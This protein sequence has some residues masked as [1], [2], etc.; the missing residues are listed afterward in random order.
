MT[1]REIEEHNV[2][3]RINR[4]RIEQRRMTV[5]IVATIINVLA[6]LAF[7]AIVIGKVVF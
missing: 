1:S 6:I 3:A 2:Q 7:M 5:M 4:E